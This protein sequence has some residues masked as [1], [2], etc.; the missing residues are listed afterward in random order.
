MSNSHQQENPQTFPPNWALTGL[1]IGRYG[2]LALS[3][4][5]GQAQAAEKKGD[6]KSVSIWRDVVN[7]LRQKYAQQDA[8]AG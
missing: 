3:H 2:D 4:A 8:F 6:Q 5:S 1:L 7:H